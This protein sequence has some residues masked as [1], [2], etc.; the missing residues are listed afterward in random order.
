MASFTSITPLPHSLRRT[1]ASRAR[2]PRGV[3][4]C[5][6]G[7]HIHLTYTSRRRGPARPSH[8]YLIRRCIAS[9]PLFILRIGGIVIPRDG[10]DH[11]DRVQQGREGVDDL[12]WAPT[13]P[14]RVVCSGNC[15]D[16]AHG[17]CLGMRISQEKVRTCCFLNLR[18]ASGRKHIE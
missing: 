14:G 5:F 11:G 15:K 4:K 8:A 18:G 6:N 3:S 7:C 9:G 1:K 17:R 16:G 2:A 13:V 12:G 10:V